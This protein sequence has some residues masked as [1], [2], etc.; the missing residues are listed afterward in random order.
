M[1]KIIIF[2][3]TYKYYNATIKNV[4]YLP[5]KRKTGIEMKFK[6]DKTRKVVLIL[7]N[8]VLI[9]GAVICSLKYFF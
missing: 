3:M 7:I 6:Y 5:F 2:I 4:N 1:K 8:I 9:L